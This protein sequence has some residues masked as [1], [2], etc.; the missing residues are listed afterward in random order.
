MR[1]FIAEKPG[2]AT[3]IAEALG[4]GR[5]CSG[6]YQC[7]D[8]VVTWCIGHLLEL[9]PAEVYNPAYKVW[10]AA[11]LPLQL[12]PAQ[13]QP[14]E[15][16]QDQLKIVGQ[17]IGQATEIVHAGDPDDEGQLLV[18]EVLVYFGNN[19]P[20]KRLL[21][22]DLNATA[23]SK[24]LRV[25]RDNSEFQGLYRK[26]LARSIGDQLYGF[27]MTRACTLAARS[28]GVKGVLS[29]GRVQTPILGLIV[30]RYLANRSHASAF[31]FNLAASIS[32]GAGNAK[33][34]L[35]VADN[36]PTD[37]KGR[38]TD[39]AYAE[40]LAKNCRQVAANVTQAAV[41]EKKESAPL[42]F[43]LLDLQVYM[44]Q[45][46][47]ID[48]EKTLELTQ[49]LREKHKAITYNRSDCKYLSEEQFAEAPHT[50][51]LLSQ[52]LPDRRDIFLQVNSERKSRAFNASKV[53]AHTGII[54]TMVRIDVTQLSADERTVYMAIV[55]RYLAQFLPEKR[56]L[57]AEVVFAVAGNSFISRAN[58]V[59]V[60]G[61]SVLIAADSTEDS[62]DAEDE[63]GSRDEVGSPFELLA[64]LQIG[65]HGQCDDV[66]IS[67][68][69]TKPPALY[70]EATLLKD[71]QRVA[72]YVIDPRI[73]QLLL[74]RDRG[75][76][77]EHGG[78]GTPATRAAMLAKLKERGFYTVE[79]K[80]L[81]P[82]PLGLAFI[83]ALPPIATTPDM[84]ALWHEQQQMIEAG[85]LTVDAF[86]DGLES[87][88]AEQVR[89]VDLG[90]VQGL[91]QT[92]PPKVNV[93][94][95]MCGK[96]L[97]TT[98]K[99]VAC[100]ACTFKFFPEIASKVL[101]VNQI[102]TLLTKGRTGVLKGF[103]SK[104]GKPF[105][106][107]LRLDHE[108]KPEFVFNKR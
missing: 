57:S 84:T 89:I 68:E 13:Y 72:K 94:C 85:E 90:G 74:D 71:L 35:M 54:P 108:A 42:P 12:R 34:K 18:D 100:R 4:N 38:I 83:S 26:A 105:E 39:R 96:E 44:S 49:A 64:A 53:T 63:P 86:L 70:T 50:L 51:D 16:T 93:P 33:A 92:E 52:A 79:K 46:H 60:P 59:T 58:K 15:K 41:V 45:A 75:K 77:G 31:Y 102:E 81:V 5:R 80:K 47:G 8:D 23:A 20:V 28:H 37:D 91:G 101:T 1:V 104:A 62:E 65:Q 56:Y 32:I 19:R 9:C 69:K 17:L 36:A 40:A 99:F 29:V 14:I 10:S 97:V 88:I 95:P 6:F 87:F 66:T 27:N 98:S 48:S 107:A 103:K 30:N 21:I 106:A 11:D 2:L 55:D 25:M 61:W 43:A 78:I 76:T 7:G 3:V 67:Q 22:N 82:T 24:A 73:K